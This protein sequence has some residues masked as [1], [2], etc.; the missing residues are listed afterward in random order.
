MMHRNLFIYLIFEEEK[1]EIHVSIPMQSLPDFFFN[2]LMAF[3]LF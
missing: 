2:S 3:K 1:E